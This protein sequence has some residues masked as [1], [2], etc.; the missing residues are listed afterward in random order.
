MYHHLCPVSLGTPL[1]PC[2]L[3]CQNH[4]GCGV[5]V[6]LGTHA[7]PIPARHC[8]AS[9]PAALQPAAVVSLATAITNHINM[10]T[11]TQPI[12]IPVAHNMTHLSD[13]TLLC[14]MNQPLHAAPPA[15]VACVHPHVNKAG[16]GASLSVHQ[17]QSP[18]T[19]GETSAQQKCQQHTPRKPAGMAGIR[20]G[21]AR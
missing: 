9:Y 11:I 7:V 20:K 13:V 17:Q 8:I 18:L 12:I 3:Q 19:G 5:P 1:A 21:K 2:V 10:H 14:N 4:P 6:P 15:P 16:Q